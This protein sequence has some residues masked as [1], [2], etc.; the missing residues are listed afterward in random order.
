MTEFHMYECVP[1]VPIVAYS[2]AASPP[3]PPSPHKLSRRQYEPLIS[4]K[5]LCLNAH[6]SID[7]RSCFGSVLHHIVVCFQVCQ[8]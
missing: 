8:I 5:C 4:F 3:P 1:F 2:T 6:S 7:I